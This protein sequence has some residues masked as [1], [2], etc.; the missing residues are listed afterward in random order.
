[1][2]VASLSSA[3]RSLDRK[4]LFFAAVGGGPGPSA[5][6]TA[7]VAAEAAEAFTLFSCGAGAS[8]V[9]LPPPG[10]GQQLSSRKPSR[11]MHARF[12]LTVSATDSDPLC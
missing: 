1:M 8:T 6:E 9:R 5:L 2:P 12:F 7:A 4:I 3:A 11:E 10:C